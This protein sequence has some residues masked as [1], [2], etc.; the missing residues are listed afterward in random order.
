[1]ANEWIQWGAGPRACIY[2]IKAAKT[3]A[4]LHGN[5]HVSVEDVRA[6]AHPVMRHRIIP[7]FVA[8]AEGYTSDKL[9]D[10]LLEQIPADKEI[11][12]ARA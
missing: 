2:L 12:T 6:L 3:R 5:L 4:V 9:I 8:Q 7:N 1:M 10:M 11:V